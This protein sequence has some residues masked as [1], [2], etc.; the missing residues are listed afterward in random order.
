MSDAEIRFTAEAFAEVEL[1]RAERQDHPV[2]AL[3]VGQ[4]GAGK[5]S[6]ASDIADRLDTRGGYVA[7]DADS[8]RTRLPYFEELDPSAVDI[9]RE[10][11]ADTEQLAGEIRRLAIEGQRNIVVDTGMHTPEASLQ[12]ATDLKRAGYRVELHALAVNDQIS[13]ERATRRYE[14]DLE[15]GSPALYVSQAAHDQSFR[16]AGN[17]VRRLEYAASPDWVTVYNRLNDA[18]VDKAPVAGHAT[19][20]DAFDRARGQLTNYERINLAEKWDEIVESMER[21]GAPSGELDRVQHHIERAH[22]TLRSTPAAAE[23]Y[24]Y[25]NPTETARSQELA[26]SYGTKLEHAFRQG[27]QDQ[28]VKYPEL[29]DAFTA[30]AAANRFVE[31]R[32]NVPADRFGDVMQ[33]RIAQGLRTGQQLQPVQLRDQSAPVQESATLTR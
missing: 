22:Y 24:D 12:L 4:E 11:R 18:I 25:N 23:S 20:G 33:D 32:P 16:D 29:R 21:R 17:T 14:S 15:A 26:K 9:A 13:Y 31:H 27:Q 1:S 3:L 5:V 28:V 2:A 8:L 7:I 10:T 19:A 30:Q 6:L